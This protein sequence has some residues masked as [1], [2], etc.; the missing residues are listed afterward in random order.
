MGS[1]L[2]YGSLI[3]APSLAASLYATIGVSGILGIDCITF[4]VAII[5]LI[6]RRIPQPAAP[7][8][9]SFKNLRQD[10]GSGFRLLFTHV[11]LRNLLLLLLP[12]GF[13]HDLGETL[14]APMILARTNGSAAALGQI[15]TAAGLG[16]VTGAIIV[17][18]WGGFKQ[19]SLGV[20]TAMIGAG[21]SKMTVGLGRSLRVW[22]PA[23][24][25]S[26]FNFPLMDSSETAIWMKNVAP[27]MQ[28]RV[29]AANAF[30]AQ[31]LSALAMIVAGP[32]GDLLIEPAMTSQTGL[33]QGLGRIFGT[34]PGA[35]FALIYT[36]CALSMIA[37]GVYGLSRRSLIT[38][39]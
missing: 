24:F 34:A 2:H 8:S 15:G 31:C 39:L 32:L 9:A 21:L 16:G 10:L 14:Y 28:G 38:R 26:S 30:L 11:P 33:S 12:F 22:L 3:L 4:G 37:I 23:Q 13:V 20:F 6:S 29:F 35:G 7:D 19:S 18:I 5:T 1:A 25:C 36:T 27:E 17:S